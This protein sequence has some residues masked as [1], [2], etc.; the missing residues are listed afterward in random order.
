MTSLALEG[1]KGVHI[2]YRGNVF[3][4]GIF[5]MPGT[6]LASLRPGVCIIARLNDDGVC[7]TRNFGRLKSAPCQDQRH[8]NGDRL[9]CHVI[10]PVF[11]HVITVSD[12]DVVALPVLL[13]L[14]RAVQRP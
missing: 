5:S 3:K 12:S 10:S 4:N 13:G 1:V 9:R 8:A 6:M 2:L 11:R 7:G 14:E